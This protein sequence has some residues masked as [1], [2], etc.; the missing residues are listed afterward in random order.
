M[1][2]KLVWCNEGRIA[3]RICRSDARDLGASMA[4][5][6]AFELGRLLRHGTL[7]ASGMPYYSQAWARASVT[8]QLKSLNNAVAAITQEQ[9]WLQSWTLRGLEMEDSNTKS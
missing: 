1:Y 4:P 6:P 5:L 9:L 2:S 7:T 3:L 8:G